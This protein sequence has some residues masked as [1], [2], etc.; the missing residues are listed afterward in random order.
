M[1]KGT[2]G[3]E[4]YTCCVSLSRLLLVSVCVC[5]CMLFIRLTVVLVLLA[6]DGV[7]TVV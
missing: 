4:R 3:T 7:V 2:R 1:I 5:V 6:S